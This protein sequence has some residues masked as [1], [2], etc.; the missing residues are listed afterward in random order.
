ME[1]APRVYLIRVTKVADDN[2]YM[3]KIHVFYI[4]HS[5]LIREITQHAGR[6]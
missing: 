1:A 3:I 5:L 4:L 6:F 2:H